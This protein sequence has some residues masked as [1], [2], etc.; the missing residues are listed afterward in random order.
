[1]TERN[2]ISPIR[3]LHDERNVGSRLRSIESLA[4]TIGKD[5]FCEQYILGLFGGRVL[6]THL[7]GSRIES[8]G[9]SSEM[10]LELREMRSTLGVLLASCNKLFHGDI[11]L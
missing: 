11:A 10:F 2:V 9:N 1:M 5:F 7:N 3:A 4:E 8:M 6:N